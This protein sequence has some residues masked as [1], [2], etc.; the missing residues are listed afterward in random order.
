[1]SVLSSNENDLIR[2][3]LFEMAGFECKQFDHTTCYHYC[4]ESQRVGIKITRNV[5]VWGAKPG[6]ELIECKLSWSDVK[7]SSMTRDVEC[8]PHTTDDWRC[9]ECRR[10]ILEMS[11]GM[12]DIWNLKS[13][14]Y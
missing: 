8:A 12:I 5:F 14:E 1:M 4:I 6:Y 9:E 3:D 7:Y 11:D 2:P 13:W 10:V